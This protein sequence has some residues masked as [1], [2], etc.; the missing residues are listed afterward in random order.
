MQWRCIKTATTTTAEAAAFVAS[1]YPQDLSRLIALHCL[2][3]LGDVEQRART[4]TN[5][6]WSTNPGR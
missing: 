2:D 1:S 4:N 6:L 3:S 5:F